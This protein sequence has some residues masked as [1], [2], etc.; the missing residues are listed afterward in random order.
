[1]KSRTKWLS[2]FVIVALIAIVGGVLWYVNQAKQE[3]FDS[4]RVCLSYSQDWQ[5][6]DL[7]SNNL[8]KYIHLRLRHTSPKGEFQ[9]TSQDGQADIADKKFQ[10]SVVTKLE[11]ELSNFKLITSETTRINGSDAASFTYEYQ[12]QNNENQ[13]VSNRQQLV[14][15]PASDKVYYIT[16]QASPE[17]FERIAG[18]TKD[19]IEDMK[20]VRR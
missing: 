6:E 20:Q 5:K 9:I 12:Y 3:C 19:I 4:G 2:V 13:T 17:D 7:K 1:M 15:W 16:I 11:D 8:D 14:I 18:A 10:D